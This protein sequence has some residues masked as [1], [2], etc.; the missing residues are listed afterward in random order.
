[1]GRQAARDAGTI[2]LSRR[3]AALRQGA[4]RV[5]AGRGADILPSGTSPFEGLLRLPER[6][7]PTGFPLPAG[8]EEKP[9]R[10]YAYKKPW[11][12]RAVRLVDAAGERLFSRR[13][14]RPAE[15]R[16]VLVLRPDHLGDV[17]FALPAIQALRAALPGA[18]IDLLVATGSRPL[19]PQNVGEGLEFLFFD[20]PWLAR[21]ARARAGLRGALSLARQL[22]RRARETGGPYDLAVDL[23]GDFRL[24]LAARLAGARYLAGRGITGLGFLLDAEAREVAGRHQVEGNLALLEAAGFDHR[25]T[26]NPSIVLTQEEIEA[27]RAVLRG[28]GVAGAKLVVGVHPG[29]GLATKRWAPEKYA[30]LIARIASELPAR[31][32]LLGGPGDRP[33]ADAVLAAL[34]EARSSR[35]LVDLCGAL[36]DLRAFMGVARACH[37]FVGND[38]GPAHIAAALGVPVL[39]LFSAT[40]DP[41]EWGPRGGAVVVLRRRIECEGCGLA[42]C[43]HHSCMVQLDVEAVFQAVR[44][45]V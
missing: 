27:G 43:G 24:I 1:M 33:A 13:R 35:R 20:A 5:H 15:I 22:R 4:E 19:F 42:E 44:R 40:N 45:C 14:E 9:P 10:P 7:P 12:C 25:E 41:A 31:V 16:R 8:R 37:L 28:H 11:V 17:V 23:R 30:T 26:P 2:M 3:L 39:C 21:P 18:R 36:P 34:G 29:A 32:V 6:L 38:S